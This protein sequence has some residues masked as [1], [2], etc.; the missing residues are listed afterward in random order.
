MANMSIYLAMWV[1]VRVCVSR[2]GSC[3]FCCS[4]CFYPT[5][6][7]FIVRRKTLHKLPFPKKVRFF[8]QRRRRHAHRHSDGNLLVSHCI[9]A[10][11]KQLKTPGHSHTHAHTHTSIQIVS[12]QI[13]KDRQKQWAGQRRQVLLLS[14]LSLEAC[15]CVRVCIPALSLCMYACV[16]ALLLNHLWLTV[17]TSQGGWSNTTI[18]SISIHRSHYAHSAPV[19]A[20]SHPPLLII[21]IIIFLF[22]QFYLIGFASGHS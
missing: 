21:I 16:R 2:C 12:C 19:A 17:P 10:G 3:L 1:W 6:A 15:V 20:P 18:E 13:N 14:L 11:T 4:F 22:C 7:L 8:W 5:H 9:V